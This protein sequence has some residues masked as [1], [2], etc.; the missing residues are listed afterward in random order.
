M[1]TNNFKIRVIDNFKYI[2]GFILIIIALQWLEENLL[3]NNW[4]V[5]LIKTIS[6]AALA[7]FIWEIFASHKQHEMTRELLEMNHASIKSGVSNYWGNFR[8]IDWESELSDAKEIEVFVHYARTLLNSNEELFMALAN[9]GTK[10]TFYF[11]NFRNEE[12]MKQISASMRDLT[13]DELVKKINESIVFVKKMKSEVKLVNIIPKYS[14]YFIDNKHCIFSPGK[15][16]KEKEIVPGLKF[17]QN[18]YTNQPFFDYL[19]NERDFL[20]ENSEGV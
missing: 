11:P 19:A 6:I 16:S 9:S 2:I 13:V 5:Q 4:M 8:K 3:L 1:K 17:T 10:F 7:A 20:K 18:I 12:L 14:F 15:H